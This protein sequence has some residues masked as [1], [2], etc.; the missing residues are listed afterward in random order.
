MRRRRT[1]RVSQHRR[2]RNIVVGRQHSNREPVRELS[3]EP[4]RRHLPVTDT[5]RQRRWRRTTSSQRRRRRRIGRHTITTRHR[6]ER[7]RINQLH[8]E[9]RTTPRVTCRHLH[10]RRGSHHRHREPFPDIVQQAAR[11]IRQPGRRAVEP[12][13]NQ[14]C[15]RQ[16]RL[17]RDRRVQRRQLVNIDPRRFTNTF[18]ATA[19][20][21]DNSDDE[22]D[23]QHQPCEPDTTEPADIHLHH[24]HISRTNSQQ[25]QQQQQLNTNQSAPTTRHTDRHPHDRRHHPHTTS[26]WTAP[27]PDHDSSRHL[28][29]R[30]M[31]RPTVGRRLARRHRRSRTHTRLVRRNTRWTSTVRRPTRRRPQRTTTLAPRR[32]TSAHHQRQPEHRPLTP[33]ANLRRA[34]PD[35]GRR[36]ADPTTPSP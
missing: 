19:P 26:C 30:Q 17:E 15:D 20:D 14:I 12:V 3:R 2:H 5:S 33:D 24:G 11:H 25:V 28:D 32:T 29:R 22:H 13:G 16:R 27:G 9:H 36:V 23:R 21:S 10:I 34:P 6:H 8:T 35:T 7:C 4:R 18:A 31:G 1:Q